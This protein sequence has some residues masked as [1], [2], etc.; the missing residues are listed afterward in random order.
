MDF[1]PALSANRVLRPPAS[2]QIDKRGGGGPVE[3]LE[4]EALGPRRE[5][6]GDPDSGHLRRD[7][8]VPG[9]RVQSGPRAQGLER[10]LAGLV[11]VKTMFPCS[12][13]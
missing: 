9:P 13:A 8:P 2:K 11:V 12:S 10:L 4:I 5:H 3:P 6:H 1:T 7:H